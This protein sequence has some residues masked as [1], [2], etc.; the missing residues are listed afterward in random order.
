VYITIQTACF[1]QWDLVLL[2]VNNVT[3]YAAAQTPSLLP[4]GMKDAQDPHLRILLQP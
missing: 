3:P 2:L 1:E 4:K